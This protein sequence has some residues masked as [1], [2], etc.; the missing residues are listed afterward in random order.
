MPIAVPRNRPEKPDLSQRPGVA[1][2]HR[3]RRARPCCVG[4]GGAGWVWPRRRLCCLDDP[5]APVPRLPL[6]ARGDPVG[7]ALLPSATFRFSVRSHGLEQMLAERGGVMAAPARPMA[8]QPCRAGQSVDQAPHSAHA[9]VQELRH[10]APGDGWDRNGGDT[11]RRQVRRVRVRATPPPGVRRWSPGPRRRPRRSPS[12]S[13]GRRGRAAAPR[14][15]RPRRRAWRAAPAGGPACPP[16]RPCP[17]G[18]ARP[19]RKPVNHVGRPRRKPRSDSSQQ[20]FAPAGRI[21]GSPT[22]TRQIGSLRV[23]STR[24][25]HGCV[26]GGPWSMRHRGGRTPPPPR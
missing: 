17:R 24:L 26:S 8:R 11:R 18:R 3:G 5:D 1:P 6:P 23:F 12:R 10:G 22:T 2:P 13:P 16:A 25:A 7:R 19:H 4:A 9:G 20:D 21:Q 14:S 15:D